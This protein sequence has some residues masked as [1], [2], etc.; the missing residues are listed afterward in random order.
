MTWAGVAGKGRTMTSAFAM[1]GRD[2]IYVTIGFVISLLI[3]SGVNPA[4]GKALISG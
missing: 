3:A 1:V 2:L 4:I